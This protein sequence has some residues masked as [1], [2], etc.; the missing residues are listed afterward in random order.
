M[1]DVGMQAGKNGAAIAVGFS[2]YLLELL[3]FSAESKTQ[4]EMLEAL[5]AI[6]NKAV[7]D[8][9]RYKV[10]EISEG[11]AEAAAKKL[12]E[13]GHDAE[14]SSVDSSIPGSTV[15]GLFRA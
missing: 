2:K 3:R 14:I 5:R 1:A 4:K 11:S 10:Y 9:L 8:P 7:D 13:Q 15:M 12:R 6:Y